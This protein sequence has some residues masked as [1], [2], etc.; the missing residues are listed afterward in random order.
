MGIIE[1]RELA[2]DYLKM[3]EEGKVE[4]RSRAVDD[5]D[6]NVREGDFVAILGHNGSGKSTLAKHIN[7]LLLPTEGTLY[8]DGK[9]TRDE[10][11][12]WEIRQTAGM[13]FQNPDNQIIGTIVD[14]DVGFG[15]ENMGVPQQEIWERVEQSLKAVGMW[16][17]RSHSPNKL[18][19][20]QKQ[21]VAIAGVVAM[22]PKCIVLDE[23]TAMLDPNGR[24]EVIHTVHELN[25]REHVTVLL[26]THYMEE[27]IDADRVI[28]MDH[29]RVVMQGM[30]REIF[31]QVEE[32][33]K[34]RLDVPQATLTAHELRK[35]GL[36]LPAGILSNEE[37]I[38]ELERL[39]ESTRRSA[40]M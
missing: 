11:K 9:N 39:R 35:A 18:S 5:I 23:P 16:E 2:F 20:G 13:V 4:S 29:G 26:I 7:A 37:L 28:V 6:L 1:A 36:E 34:Y 22:R 21:R 38:C 33:K 19:G 10:T 25:R 31:S 8:V 40:A 17:Y 14:E 24:R 30:P 15:P 27:V 32:L 3:N 12:L